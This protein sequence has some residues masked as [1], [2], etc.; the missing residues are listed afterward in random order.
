[1]NIYDAISNRILDNSY[2]VDFGKL[3]D[4]V[5]GNDPSKIKR[6][7]LYG[8]RPPQND[9]LWDIAERAGF[10]TVVEDRNI[11]NREKRVDTGIVSAMVRDAYTRADKENDTITLVAGDG[12]YIPALQD[13]TGDGFT[14]DVVFWDHASKD[15]KD[16]CTNFISLNPHLAMLR[17]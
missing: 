13:L 1:M 10:E 2:R 12:D 5:A 7:V 17:P 6:A 16:A 14:V 11:A 9:S 8:S 3:H 15:L 4:F